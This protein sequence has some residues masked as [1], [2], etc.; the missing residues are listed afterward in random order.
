MYWH[1]QM[2][3]YVS[4]PSRFCSPVWRLYFQIQRR[5]S[6][7]VSCISYLND[8]F[9]PPLPLTCTWRRSLRRG[10]VQTFIDISLC[11]G[12]TGAYVPGAQRE[13]HFSM[14]NFLLIFLILTP[15]CIGEAYSPSPELTDA[16]ILLRIHSLRACL[17]LSEIL[18]Q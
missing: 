9:F 6:Q 10:N 7:I 4:F 5:S 8:R 3:R 2:L 17:L 15:P 13:R 1:R 14:V 12:T 16:D 18:A 11:I